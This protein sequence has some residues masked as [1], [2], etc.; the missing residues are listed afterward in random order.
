M[1][2]LEKGIGKVYRILEVILSALMLIG[3]ILALIG[4][5]RNYTIFYELLYSTEAFQHYLDDIFTIVIGIEF[6]QMLCRHSS[7][8]VIDAIIFLIARHMIV[9]STTPYEDFVSVLSIVILCLVRYYLHHD[10]DKKKFYKNQDE[11]L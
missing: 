8:N 5:F 2:L 3:I 7:N 6:L 11:L 1:N 4:V 10:E 9:S